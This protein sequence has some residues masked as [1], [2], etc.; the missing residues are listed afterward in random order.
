MWQKIGLCPV[1]KPNF[2]RGLEPKS[3][4]LADKV[5][6]QERAETAVKTESKGKRID[7]RVRSRKSIVAQTQ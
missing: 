5:T 3:S 4:T 6:G 2:I 7:K 1:I